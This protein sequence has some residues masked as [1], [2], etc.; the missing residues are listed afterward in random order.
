MVLSGG[1]QSG[2]H[3]MSRVLAAA[4][5]LLMPMLLLAGS[6]EADGDVQTIQSSE[7]PSAVVSCSF[8]AS[9]AKQFNSVLGAE[10]VNPI[11]DLLGR[12]EGLQCDIGT[13]LAFTHHDFIVQMDTT[14]SYSGF[15]DESTQESALFVTSPI[16]EFGD[17]SIVIVSSVSPERISVVGVD[18]HLNAELL[19]DTIRKPSL[20]KGAAVN[21]C[22][23]YGLEVVAPGRLLMLERDTGRCGPQGAKRKFL[24]DVSRGAFSLTT[25]SE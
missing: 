22:S 7:I 12:L 17:K 16:A 20:S 15:H 24:L 10:G 18:S 23:V 21:I 25:S 5:W 19:Y 8:V 1:L 2:V 11:G 9:Y 14:G 6:V 13:R 4:A 3:A